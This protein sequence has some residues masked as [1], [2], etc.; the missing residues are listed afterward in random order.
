MFC[1][2]WLNCTP[3]N[4]DIAT[5]LYLGNGGRNVAGND[6]ERKTTNKK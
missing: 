1:L 6:N 4:L 5:L 3:N 2:R